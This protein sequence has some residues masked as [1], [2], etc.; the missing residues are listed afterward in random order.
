MQYCERNA[1]CVEYQCCHRGRFKTYNQAAQA[2][3]IVEASACNEPVYCQ[4]DDVALLITL[5]VFILATLVV[6]L[7]CCRESW[8]QQNMRERI[9]EQRR[10]LYLRQQLEL[11]GVSPQQAH[12]VLTM[13]INSSFC[14]NQVAA[15]EDLLGS[16]QKPGG[17]IMPLSSSNN[18]RGGGD[19]S[20]DTFRSESQPEYNSSNPSI[21]YQRFSQKWLKHEENYSSHTRLGAHSNHYRERDEGMARPEKADSLFKSISYQK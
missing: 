18:F 15:F 16:N 8:V 7:N 17:T 5:S 2:E 6:L 21:M 9:R 20:S 12:E 1:Q 14:R 3:E 13:D 11:D 4:E 19:S 10:H